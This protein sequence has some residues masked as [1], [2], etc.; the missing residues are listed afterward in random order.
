MESSKITCNSF[1]SYIWNTLYLFMFQSCLRAKT[2]KLL[3]VYVINMWLG[4]FFSNI[5]SYYSLVRGYRVDHTIQRRNLHKPSAIRDATTNQHVYVMMMSRAYSLINRIHCTRR[6]TIY[7]PCDESH[8][9]FLCGG[10]SVIVLQSNTI[11]YRLLLF[12]NL[13]MHCHSRLHPLYNVASFAVVHLSVCWKF[14]ESNHRLFVKS[15]SWMCAATLYVVLSIAEATITAYRHSN[16]C[17]IYWRKG[18]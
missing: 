16:S 8:F 5:A 1:I 10:S 6:H 13:Y 4:E 18:C 9:D 2:F 12:I 17:G 11:F 3:N 7:I 14:I 15:T